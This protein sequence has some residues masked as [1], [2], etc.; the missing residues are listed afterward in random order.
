MAKNLFSPIAAKTKR[1]P[2]EKLAGPEGL[3]ET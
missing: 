3:H 1:G 2:Q